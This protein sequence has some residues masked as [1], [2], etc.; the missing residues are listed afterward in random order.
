MPNFTFTATLNNQVSTQARSIQQSTVAAAAAL[1]NLGAAAAKASSQMATSMAAANSSVATFTVSMNKANVASGNFKSGLVSIASAI[2]AVKSAFSVLS[3]GIDQTIGRMARFGTEALK[4]FSAR[5][6]QLRA[7][8]QILNGDKGEAETQYGRAQDIGTKTDF[9]SEQVIKAQ[10][11]LFMSGYRGK[12]ADKLL[13]G[14]LDVA[15]AAPEGERESRLKMYTDA[16]RRIQGRQHLSIGDL[17][18]SFGAIGINSGLIKEY[19]AKSYGYAGKN[20]KDIS[21]FVDKKLKDKDV[22]VSTA[23]GAL[24]Y[25][26]SKQFNNGGALGG[27]ATNSLGSIQSLQS[28]RDEMF[29]KL[30]RSYSGDLLPAVRQYKDALRA[31]TNNLDV[32]TKTGDK[33]RTVMADLANTGIG[34]KVAWENFSTGF[35]ESFSNTYTQALKDMGINSGGLGQSLRE[36]ASAAKKVGEWFGNIGTAAAHII[37]SLDDFG[38][39]FTYF[40]RAMG[41]YFSGDFKGG[42]E[43]ERSYRTIVAG[44]KIKEVQPLST[45]ELETFKTTGRLPVSGEKSREASLNEMDK[46]GGEQGAGKGG[47][48]YDASDKERGALPKVQPARIASGPGGHGERSGGHHGGGGGDGGSFTG[49][50]IK[51]GTMHLEMHLHGKDWEEVKHII[52]SEATGEVKQLFERLATEMGV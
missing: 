4:N 8:T 37:H 47:G 5:E 42:Q 49:G 31:S 6:S 23:T 30:Q 38:L 11:S 50:G 28:N 22:D 48:A 21:E 44:R 52:A 51:I 2:Y 24:K 27:F 20:P 29:D 7:Y 18:R 46:F 1:G 16:L 26:I 35:L 33:F 32:N 39:F 36:A 17:N 19:I 45:A 43:T 25:A 15:T 41:Q 10:S 34:L 9:T 40:T 12:E 13:A 14:G 3:W